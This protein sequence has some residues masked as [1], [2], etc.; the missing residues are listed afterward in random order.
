VRNSQLD[1]EQRV[2]KTMAESLLQRR[3]L[4]GGVLGVFILAGLVF[5]GWGYFKERRDKS[6]RNELYSLQ[7]AVQ[8]GAEKTAAELKPATDALEQKILSS[9]SDVA[10]VAAIGLGDHYL[11][12]KQPE[13]ALA[14]IEKIYGKV[15]SSPAVVAALLRNLYGNILL[16]QGQLEK[17]IEV[18]SQNLPLKGGKEDL[19]FIE[20]TTLLQRATAYSRSGK[21][22]LA[23]ADV[24]RLRADHPD[25]QAVKTAN[26]MQRLSVLKK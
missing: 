12:K 23:D 13:V 14:F 9:S 1:T 19:K 8:D 4:L 21:T 24:A 5:W 7:K 2:R 3:G 25:S 22:D 15:G 11:Q 26:V 18:F 17:A 20:A 10:I 6:F 16:D